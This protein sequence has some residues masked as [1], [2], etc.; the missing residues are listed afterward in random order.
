MIRS[1]APF[2][3]LFFLAACLGE[4]PR[5]GRRVAVDPDVVNFAQRGDQLILAGRVY[6]GNVL[7]ADS[8]AFVWHSVD[9][10]VAAVTLDGVLTARGDGVT[11][12]WGVSG[13]DSAFAVVVVQTPVAPAVVTV[14]PRRV[15]FSAL[16]AAVRLA[17]GSSDSLVR[18]S[19]PACRSDDPRVAV[20]DSVTVRASGNGS[21]RIRC[22]I[23]GVEGSMTVIVRQRIAQVRL[24]SDQEFALRIGRDSL[25]LELAR[26]DSL[27]QPVARG[28]AMFVSL[29]TGVVHVDPAQG[30]VVAGSLGNGRIVG[31][32]EGF[33]DTAVIRVV[34]LAPPP[35]VTVA[36]RRAGGAASVTTRRPG[37]RTVQR[38]GVSRNAPAAAQI[39]ARNFQRGDSILQAGTT[40]T[41][42]FARWGFTP[43][44]ASAQRR[45]DQGLGIDTLPEV[46]TG[47]VFGVEI[48][49]TPIRR[50]RFNLLTSAGKLTGK[51]PNGET[52]S[53]SEFRLD[54][55]ASLFPWLWVQLGAGRRAIKPTGQRLGHWD[56]LRVGSEARFGLGRGSMQGLVR[57]TWLPY[58]TVSG[59]ANRPNLGLVSEAGVDYRTGLVTFGLRYALERLDFPP[60]GANR[61][62]EQFAMLRIRAGVE[63]G[64]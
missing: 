30:T 31:S 59:A 47:P 9:S 29:D 35:V 19:L 23:A 56:M 57:M 58:V 34:E 25:N 46:S 7:A 53:V 43:F 52:G 49:A 14:A 44:A 6:R 36:G 54:A 48:E 50:L 20:V 22:G 21:T 62:R 42:P 16:T 33:A 40:A 38:A 28:A 5:S 64:R 8:A 4:R 12:V 26:V 63:L 3:A 37:V 55:G 13:T 15:Q 32:I 45:I 60:S 39:G 17:V 61:R 24:V 2:L 1:R 10:T 51:P 27:R 11:R 18:D 41:D